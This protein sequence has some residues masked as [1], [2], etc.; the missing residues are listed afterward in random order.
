[1]TGDPIQLE[2]RIVAGPDSDAAERAELA[3]R[4]RDELDHLEAGRVM[5]PRAGAAP[6][7]AKAGES[8]AVGSTLLVSLISSGA[9]TAVITTVNSWIGRQ[10]RGSVSIKLGDDDLVLTNASSEDQRRMMEQWLE[11]HGG[12]TG[13]GG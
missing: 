11:Q 4:L 7:G 2:L 9:L 12:S 1:M 10:R 3:L 5:W 6:G 8:A 13:G